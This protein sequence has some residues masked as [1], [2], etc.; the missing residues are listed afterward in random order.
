MANTKLDIR[1][2]LIVGIVNANLGYPVQWPNLPVQL[3]GSS[4]QPNNEPWLRIT[5]L[6]MEDGVST[7]GAG[8]KDAVI[9]AM[10]VDIFTPKGSGDIA[11]YNIMQEVRG[12]FAR[13]K[14]LQHSGQFVRITSAGSRTGTDE[15][16]WYS[17]IINVE[18]S[19]Y[20]TRG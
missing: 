10:Q 15:Q 17:Q 6:S 18:F 3:S 20:L 19:S 12:I 11:A 14:V 7:L 5:V 1:T 13:G 9:G 16:D 8:G 2:S 4:Y